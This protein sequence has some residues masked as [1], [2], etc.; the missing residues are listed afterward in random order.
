MAGRPNIVFMFTDQH[1]Q[2]V[3][4]CYGDRVA[5]TPNLDRLAEAGVVF[6]NAYCPAPLCVPSRMAMMAGRYPNAID[7]YGNHETLHTDIPTFAHSL[8]VAGYHTALV[9]RMHWLGPDQTHGFNERRV[10]EVG[11]TWAGGKAPELGP[12]AP[13]RSSSGPS[14]AYSG[15]GYTAHHYFD[16]DVTRDAC[17]WIDAVGAK[18]EDPFCLMVSWFLPHQ[19]FVAERDDFEV[20]RGRV[21]PPRLVPAN[22][23]HPHIRGWRERTRLLDIPAEVVDR[24]RTAYYG[25]VRKIDRMIGQVVERLRAN[26]LLDNTIV[27]YASDHGEQLGERGLWCKSTLYDQSA[28]VPLVVSWPDRLPRGARRRRIVNLIDL[29]ATLLDAASAQPLPNSQGRSFLAMAEDESRPW[30]DETFSEFYGG[31]MGVA[32]PPFQHRMIRTERWK[33]NYYHGQPSQ[34]FDMIA[35]P[36]ETHDLVDDPAFREVREELT[37]RLLADWDPERIARRQTEKAPDIELR[38]AWAKATDPLEPFRY[39]LRKPEENWLS[40]SGETASSE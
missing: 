18:A 8:G 16:V 3:A 26:G 12:V 13:A 24:V 39:P 21:P 28:K 19:P 23:E 7:C 27:V 33:L 38:R 4:G 22:A 9:G 11:P 1:A 29:N 37:G 36:D 15:I 2:R 40:P 5:D 30:T 34:L 6:D 20:F 17:A 14:F 10:G 35:D 32:A 31:L 25:N